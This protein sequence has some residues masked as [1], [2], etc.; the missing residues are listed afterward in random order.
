LAR[1]CKILVVDDSDRFRQFFVLSLRQTAEFQL[2]YEASD[3]LEAVERAEELKPDLILLD[4]G[5]PRMNGI[6]AG[7]RIRKV[8]PNSKILFVS[9]DS[10]VDVVHEALHLGAQGYLLKADAGGELLPAVYAVL[11]G[12]QYLSRRLRPHVISKT[13]DE[14]PAGSLR[15]KEHLPL[16]SQKGDIVRV[17]K[18]AFQRDD[19]SIVD[20]FTRFIE[21]ALKM[22]NPVIVIA[23][24]SHRTN[25]R[26]RLQARGRDISTAIQEGTYISL[27][28][29]DMLSEVMVNDWPDSTRLL[30]VASDLIVEAAKAAKGKHF[31][32]AACGEC[33]SSLIA[34]GKPEAAI[35]L[36]RLW[37][38]IARSHYVD[39]LCEYLLR[40]FQ[41]EES[42]PIFERICVAHSAAYTL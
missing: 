11:Q 39:I 34:Q 20:D 27:D 29:D 36:E 12:R 42:S 40:D 41:T 32:V 3:G 16:L 30:K 38:K 31:R 7:R 4:I 17:H 37:D 25:L 14:Y 33:A 28:A 24:E 21:F 26:Q 19:A 22:E 8:S 9:Q 18:V 10:S 13:H 35:E 1:S 2:I 23:T 15:S 6:E 5:L